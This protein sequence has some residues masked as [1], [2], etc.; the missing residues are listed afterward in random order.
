MR[1]LAAPAVAA[2]LSLATAASAQDRPGEFDFY[3]LALSW[4][5]TWCETAEA[6]DESRQCEAGAG[7][8][9][10]VHGLWPQ[11]ERGYPEF[12]AGRRPERIPAALAE[13]M[14]DIM[15][16]RDLVFSQ[17]RKHGTC[18]GLSPA[19][20]LAETRS[21]LQ[22]ITIPEAFSDA[23]GERT[24]SAQAAE[25]AFIAANPGLKA[26]AIAVVCEDGA[27]EEIRICLTRDLQFRSCPEVDRSGCRQKNLRLP[28]P[29]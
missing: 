15:P 28:A 25:S 23:D 17:W 19:D 27:L 7:H 16:D 29:A 26:D 13:D 22:A 11:H 5:P 14:Q 3:V 8:R 12:C 2:L 4:S 21:A 6:A 18:T 10:I 20:Y 1:I 24:L 9:F